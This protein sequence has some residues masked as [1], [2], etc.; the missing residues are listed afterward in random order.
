MNHS[1]CV[2]YGK[3]VDGSQEVILSKWVGRVH[4]GIE[5]VEIIQKISSK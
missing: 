4:T 1:E 3:L 2:D 5:W